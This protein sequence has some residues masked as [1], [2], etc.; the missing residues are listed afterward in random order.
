MTARWEELKEARPGTP[1]PTRLSP[2]LLP[3][4]SAIELR[5]HRGSRAVGRRLSSC[6]ICCSHSQGPRGQRERT[7]GQARCFPR[8][9]RRPL[10]RT[11]PSGCD[12]PIC[13]AARENRGPTS[14]PTDPAS[15]AAPGPGPR[16]FR[17]FWVPGTQQG[18]SGLRQAEPQLRGRAPAAPGDKQS[19]SSHMKREPVSLGEGRRQERPSGK[20]PSSRARWGRQGAPH[21]SPRPGLCP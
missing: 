3:S 13:R 10:Q 8:H 19:A 12:R 4:V 16:C 18:L 2:T 11:V 7:E 6:P 20:H 1:P 14:S 9:P 15:P 17:W 5:A 21:C